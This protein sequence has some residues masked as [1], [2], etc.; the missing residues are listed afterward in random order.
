M[1]LVPPK[2]VQREESTFLFSPFCFR[3]LGSD[4]HFYPGIE[5]AW[6][7]GGH[8]GHS[9]Q[10]LPPHIQSPQS[11]L[12]KRCVLQCHPSASHPPLVAT[13][14]KIILKL[15]HQVRR[16]KRPSTIWPLLPSSTAT[17]TYT[18]T[19]DNLIFPPRE[20]VRT[21]HTTAHHQ[22]LAWRPI[23]SA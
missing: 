6:S 23:S 16:H 22:S 20:V 5:S 4:Q 11:P 1:R 14:F 21:F 9:I 7:G 13:V 2:V 3:Y 18:T 19:T 17:Y 12:S 8:Y 10:V 15:P